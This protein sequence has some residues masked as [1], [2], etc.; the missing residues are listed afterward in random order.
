MDRL[1]CPWRSRYTTRVHSGDQDADSCVFCTTIAANEDEKN[2]VLKRY[3]HTL[4]MLNLYPYNAGHVLVLSNKHHSKLNDLSPEERAD[5][6]ETINVGIEIIEKTLK[7]GGFNVGFNLGKFAGAGIPKHVHCHVL[8][9]WEGDTN[10]LPLLADTK[11]ISMDLTQ[12]YRDLKT[13]FD[14]GL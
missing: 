12:M 9:R 5:F 14:R 3:A 1:Y 4:V 6:I 8:P 7:P 2:F 10:F 11:Q 13:A